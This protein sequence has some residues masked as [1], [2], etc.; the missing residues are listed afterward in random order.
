MAELLFEILSQEIPARM[1]R[2]AAADLLKLVTDGLKQAGLEHGDARAFSTPRRLSFVI[3]DL[4]EKQPDVREE[5]RGPRVDAPEKAING[6][7]GSVGLSSVDDCEQLETDKGTFLCVIIEKQGVATAEVLPDILNDA[8]AKLPWP[9]SMRWGETGFRWVRPIHSILALFDGAVLDGALDLAGGTVSFGNETAGHRFLAPDVFTVTSFA[10]YQAKLKEACVILDPGER[11]SK[12]AEDLAALAKKAGLTVKDDPGLLAEVTGLVEWPVMLLGS[13]DEAF[14]DV[15]PEVLITAIRTHLKY[16]VLEDADGKLAPHFAVAANMTTADGGKAIVAGNE[17]VLRARLADAKF[18]WDQDRKSSLASRT[19]SL[20]EIT[21]HD[22]LGTLDAKID[23]V[24]SLAVELCQHVDGAERDRVRSAARLCKAD[25]VTEMV[26]EFPELQGLMGRY[27]AL[28]D[29]E[30]EEVA[31]AIAEHYSPL[32]PGDDC[33][34]APVSVAVAMADKLDTLAGFWAIDEKPTG[35]KDPYALRRAALGVIRLI[36][37]NG[38]RVPLRRMIDQALAAQP[39]GLGNIGIAD[40]LLAFFADRLKVHLREKGVRHDLVSAVF[41]LGDEDDL[42]RLLARVEAL[43]RFVD[44]EDGA[45]L[46]TAFGRAANILRIEEKKDGVSYAADADPNAF[47]QVEETALADTLAVVEKEAAN[48]LA[49]EDFVGA[50]TAMASLRG[51]VDAFFDKVTVNAED[52]V[53]R[54]NRL[55]LLSGIRTT[56]GAVADFNEIEG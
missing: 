51:P 25:L 53:L 35:S 34:S 36:V 33:P 17:R 47:D 19:P 55:K 14:M 24:Q 31:N 3:E 15:P 8:M 6:F 7:L 13:I 46:L 29:G 37:E 56:M 40:D 42:V 44:S 54:E 21:F 12:V 10:E 18:F 9:K 49:G 48:A 20:A 52:A 41:A 28:H 38:L 23:R 26:F 50:M 2:R 4:P 39:V 30:H 43:G 32:G 16:F 27:Y 22:K 45:N 5:R 1:Q 11:E